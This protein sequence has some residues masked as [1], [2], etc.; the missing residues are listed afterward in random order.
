MGKQGTEP[1]SLE[2]KLGLVVCQESLTLKKCWKGRAT[3]IS[4][5]KREG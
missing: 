2:Q 4:E 1:L 3:L 5:E